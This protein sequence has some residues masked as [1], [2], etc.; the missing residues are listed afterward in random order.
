MEDPT[1][2]VDGCERPQHTRELCQMHYSRLM[3]TGSTGTA[4][5]R[6]VLGQEGCKVNGCN[7]PHKSKG[8]CLRHYANF[9]RNGDPISRGRGRP[10]ELSPHWKTVPTYSAMHRRVRTQRGSAGNYVCPCGAPARQWSYDHTDPDQVWEMMGGYL[11]PY[12]L[13]P[14]RYDPLCT[15]CHRR[16]D[17]DH[18]SV[19]TKQGVS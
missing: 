16:R 6:R 14:A 15:F 9:S 19:R 13:D 2:L 1:C 7:G 12:S 10:G 4:A 18:S 11:L 8:Y 17:L 3:K 5:P